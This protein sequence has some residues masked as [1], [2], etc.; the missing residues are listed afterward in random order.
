[1]HFEGDLAAVE[2]EGAAEVAR[3]FIKKK[4]IRLDGDALAEAILRCRQEG[5]AEARRTGREFRMSDGIRWALREIGAPPHAEALA[6]AATRPFFAA[7]EALHT[8]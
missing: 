2:R 6:A 3:W 1:M 5:M 7:E 8:P 4:R